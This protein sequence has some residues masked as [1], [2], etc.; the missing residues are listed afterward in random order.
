MNATSLSWGRHYLMCPPDHFTVEYAI[1]PWMTTEEP[2]DLPAA[3]HQ[4]DGVVNAIEEA[5]G[6]V[7]TIE[8]DPDLPDMVFTANAGIMADGVFAPA[9]MRFPER[10]GEPRLAAEWAVAAGY[11]VAEIKVD[12]F[13]G[14]GDA[15]PF[16]D[17]L[18]AGYGQ[19]TK[20]DAWSQLSAG[21]GWDYTP[22]ELRDPRFYHID[23]V[24]SPLNDRSALVAP[25]GLTDAGL[26][27]IKSI[28]PDPILLTDEEAMQFS[29]NSIVV[30]E[31][32]IS[33]AASPRIRRELERRG[34]NS[35]IAPVGEFLKAGGAVRCLT[36]PLDIELDTVLAQIA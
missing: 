21:L 15:L 33:P 20:L 5:G 18:I 4:W 19:R 6:V 17:M 11:D 2:V 1:N 30:G 29:A 32:V 26:R 8:P 7:S 9:R 10:A 12:T 27:T 13:E 36:L 3:R 34:F 28:V 25:A 23:I 16:R 22:I 24:F 14:M 31:T 35:I